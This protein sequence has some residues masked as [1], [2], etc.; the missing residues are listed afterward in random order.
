MPKISIIVP[1]YNTAEYLEECLD[2]IHRQS[3]AD[4]EA[5]CI[6][7]G[8]EDGS[9]EILRRYGAEDERFVLARQEQRGAAAAR[10]MGISMSRGEYIMFLD[11]DDRYLEDKA[12]EKLY[13]AVKEN[14]ARV[15]AGRIKRISY[16]HLTKVEMFAEIGELPPGGRR[17]SFEEYQEDYYYQAYIFERRLLE[18]GGV[19]FPPYRRYE[20][21]PFLLQLLPEAE[22]ILL[23][24]LAFYGYRWGHHR[25]SPE[26][27]ADVLAGIMDNLKVAVR[28]GYGK[29]QKKLISRLND[30]FRQ[31]ILG[32]PIL[33]V[34][35]ILLKIESLNVQGNAY[36]PIQAIPILQ[37]RLSGG[38]ALAQPGKEYVF[39][40]H[41]F[42]RGNKVAIYGAGNVGRKFYRQAIE[43][44]YIEVAGLFDKNVD[45]LP[46]GVPVQPA[47]AL[48]GTSCDGV[49]IA[50]ENEAVAADIREEII[51]MGIDENK[52]FWVGNVYEKGNFLREVYFHILDVKNVEAA[53]I[54]K[55]EE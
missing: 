55:W 53:K 35:P 54:R 33:E 18:G 20:D 31:E 17:V 10:N 28:Y 26:Y 24:P 51:N 48:A 27:I 11:S 45:N 44:P 1:V 32:A 38:A 8:S 42:Q 49:L 22:K 37:N 4:W 43:H 19:I 7:D 46:K 12:L 25:Q 15:A 29:L 21:P 47:D 36:T 30:D 9:W 41:L 23:L 5:I 13:V 14:K 6:D 34:L 52:I 2:S 50:V 16:G 40:Y 39:P 3:L